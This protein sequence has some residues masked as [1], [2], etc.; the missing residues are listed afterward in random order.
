M[1]DEPLDIYRK[2]LLSIAPVSREEERECIR[3]L[4]AGGEQAETAETPS[5]IA[6]AAS[7]FW[8]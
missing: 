4:R 6:G 7:T 5:G 3:H 8:T 2:E 1:I